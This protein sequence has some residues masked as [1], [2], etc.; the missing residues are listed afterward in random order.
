MIVNEIPQGF[1][2]L[3]LGG[4]RAPDVVAFNH[5]CFGLCYPVSD[6]FVLGGLTFERPRDAKGN[7]LPLKIFVKQVQQPPRDG[8]FAGRG[9]AFA[10]T[11]KLE[12]F[13][14]DFPYDPLK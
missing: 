9:A 2:R 12:E 7:L 13:D 11:A 4:T 3:R 14:G 1:F 5:E 10:D 6:P 8:V